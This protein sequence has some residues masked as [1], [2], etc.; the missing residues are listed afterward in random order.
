MNDD[1]MDDLV[2]Q[3]AKDYNEPGDGSAR[4]DVGA[5]QRSAPGRA[6]DAGGRRP[7]SPAALRTWASVRRRGG[8][9]PGA[10]HRHRSP[11]RA[12]VGWSVVGRR[13]QARRHGGRA[14]NSTA[15]PSATVANGDSI[16]PGA[17]HRKR[18]TRNV[19]PKSWR[20]PT[21]RRQ[22]AGLWSK[23]QPRL[24]AR[25]AAAPRRKRGDDHRRS[26]RRPSAARWTRR[27]PAGRE[28]C[29]STTR[30]LEASPVTQD[31][32]MKRLLEDLDLVIVQISALRDSWD[33]Q[34]RRPR[35]HR[36]IDQQARR[37]QQAAQHPSRPE[38]SGGH[39]RN[40]NAEDSALHLCPDDIRRC[41][42]R[43][44]AGD[45]AHRP[46]GNG[47]VRPVRRP[48]RLALSARPPGHHR[49]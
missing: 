14:R 34:S 30:M 3:G 29:L 5:H 19:A 1:Q 42:R 27:S 49:R 6:L 20:P 16:D 35:S 26:A 8:G 11:A 44:A 23:R 41:R 43:A 24:P 39:L 48:G 37:H 2:V 7:A 13:R 40:D 9:G 33:E 4:G 47:A 22:R 10:W 12:S 25:G 21:S 45:G 46:R 36:T 31:P 18:R 38:C 28:S 17:S 15:E 32:T